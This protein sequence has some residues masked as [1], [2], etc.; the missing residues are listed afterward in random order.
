VLDSLADQ[1]QELIETAQTIALQIFPTTTVTFDKKHYRPRQQSKKRDALVLMQTA[2]KIIRW[3]LRTNTDTHTAME[4]L[5]HRYSRMLHPPAS[6]THERV[7]NLVVREVTSLAEQGHAI[8]QAAQQLIPPETGDKV[9]YYI[10]GRIIRQ[11]RNAIKSI[12][13]E[14]TTLAVQQLKKQQRQIFDN[15]QKLGHK[16][17]KEASKNKIK[18]TQTLLALRDSAGNVVTSPADIKNVTAHYFHEALRSPQP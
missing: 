5:A 18:P 15:R 9:G 2:A 6:T 14:H 17:V 12:D 13:R 4:R 7:F 3:Q 10:A 11:Y 1:I 16:I 8:P